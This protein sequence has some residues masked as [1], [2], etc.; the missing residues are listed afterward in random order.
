M[1]FLGII[2]KIKLFYNTRTGV[3]LMYSSYDCFY[4]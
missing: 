1:P 2:L 4:F 3:Y